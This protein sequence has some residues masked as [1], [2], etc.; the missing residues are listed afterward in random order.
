MKK[1]LVADDEEK[2]RK[3]ICDYLEA[4]GYETVTA[5][6]GIDAITRT[7]TENPDLII[8]D[9][10]M[11]G[12]DGFDSTRRIRE[13]TD[14]PIIMV[15]ARAEEADKLMGLDVGA[16]DYIV[17]PFS[18]KELAARIR[19]VL[20]RADKSQSAEE[21]EKTPS[22]ITVK[23]IRLD[24]EKMSVY[25]DGERLDLTSVQFEIFKLLISH[26]GRVFTRMQLLNAFQ[27]DA[28]EGY[29]RTIDVHIKNI[30]K[31][32]ERTPSK[33]EYIETVWGT[34]YRFAEETG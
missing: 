31:A 27:E 24:S 18:L 29:E 16:D 25:R 33:P 23:D 4:V 11:P 12:L 19:A 34:G 1:I 15:T 26:P 7:V 17:K 9:I 21:D 3:M 2:I 22:V 14:V 6:D 13:K 8:L 32:V 20:R 28:F 10:M 30:R 5:V